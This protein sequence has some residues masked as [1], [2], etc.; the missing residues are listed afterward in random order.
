MPP[1]MLAL[2][3]KRRSVCLL[4]SLRVSKQHC[5]TELDVMWRIRWSGTLINSQFLF[6]VPCCP[7]WHIPWPSSRNSVMVAEVHL[8]QGLEASILVRM[9]DIKRLSSVEPKFSSQNLE[10]S[11]D[12]PRRCPKGGNRGSENKRWFSIFVFLHNYRSTWFFPLG[13]RWVHDH[14]LSHPDAGHLGK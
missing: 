1:R 2:R 5:V 14:E 10:S 8:D 7:E 9:D 13:S 11:W 4:C 6:L 3:A 12:R